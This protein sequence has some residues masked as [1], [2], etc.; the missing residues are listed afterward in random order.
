MS[1][2][3]SP[4]EPGFGSDSFLDIIANLVGIL[5]IL[6]V[7]AGLRASETVELAEEASTVPSPLAGEGAQRAEEGELGSAVS[8]HTPVAEPPSSGLRPPSPPG[9][10]DL[11]AKREAE[12][13][14][15]AELEAERQ[16]R[17]TAIEEAA[18]LGSLGD[19]MKRQLADLKTAASRLD[20]AEA[21]STL[22]SAQAERDEFDAAARVLI[23]TRDRLEKE[24]ALA[25]AKIGEQ[26]KQLRELAT[27][28]DK[29]NKVLARLIDAEP[30]KKTLSHRVSP[31]GRVVYGDEVH[32]RI[33]RGMISHVPIEELTD[34]LRDK[35]R[36][37][38]SWL[39][40]YNR[41]A[42]KIGPVEGYR[43]DYVVARQ[44]MSAVDELR[45]GRGMVKI[46]LSEFTIRPTAELREESV[47][48]SLTESGLV[49]RHLAALPPGSP[50][51]LWVYPD[52]FG[53]YRQVAAFAQRNGFIVAGRPLPKGM[54]ISG[55]PQ[56][57]K[58]VAQ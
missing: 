16:R 24:K 55:S 44:A 19:T 57:S 33:S 53:E 15:R 58:S 56:G 22:A 21:K 36:Q 51:T 27:E 32:F 48:R 42:G 50:V 4:D 28:M 54:P 39:I 11:L 47:S 31:V 9:G 38:G 29:V 8:D 3:R 2:G 43:L 7:L 35:I 30:P 17:L 52:S 49:Y 5:I 46:S 10:A 20:E 34:I 26:S 13:A 25:K 23:A 45:S 37:N 12:L 6:I 14:A 18:R 41:H 1:R 40:K